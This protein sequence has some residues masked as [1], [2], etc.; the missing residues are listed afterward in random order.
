MKF[1]NLQRNPAMILLVTDPEDAL[2]F[3]EV[4]GVL[5]Q[6]I[7]DPTG[8]PARSATRSAK[9]SPIDRGR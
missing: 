2:R 9:C 5:D 3:V 8:A 7:D 6:V 1:R 4:R